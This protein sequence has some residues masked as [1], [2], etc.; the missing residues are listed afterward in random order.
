[1]A[2]GN[3]KFVTVVKHFNETNSIASQLNLVFNDPIIMI[4]AVPEL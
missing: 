4:C 2:S 3:N 1:M